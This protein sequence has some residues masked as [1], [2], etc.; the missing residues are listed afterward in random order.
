MN[1]DYLITLSEKSVLLV[2]V[3]FFSML[4]FSA[5]FPTPLPS[6]QGSY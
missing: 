4:S 2:P 3:S 5:I 6:T 1:F